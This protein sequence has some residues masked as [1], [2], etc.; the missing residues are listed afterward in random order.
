MFQPSST[1]GDSNIGSADVYLLAVYDNQERWMVRIGKGF[2]KILT[3]F[4]VTRQY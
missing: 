4:I 1:I 2:K 3:E